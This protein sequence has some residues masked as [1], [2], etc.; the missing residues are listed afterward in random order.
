M[1]NKVGRLLRSKRGAALIIAMFLLIIL[2]VLGLAGIQTSTTDIE[3]AANE[4]RSLC[5]LYAADAGLQEALR[6]ICRWNDNSFPLPL[7]DIGNDTFY[8]SGPLTSIGSVGTP[9][10]YNY[11]LFDVEITGICGDP[12]NPRASRKEIQIMPRRLTLKDP[13]AAPEYGPTSYN[14][15]L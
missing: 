2:T 13:H 10:G 11:E 9:G 1:L 14:V 8:M 4:R 5:A 15:G 12:N 6:Q 7:T 3:I